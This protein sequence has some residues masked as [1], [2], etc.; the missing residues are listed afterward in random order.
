MAANRLPRDKAVVSGAVTKNAGR[1]KDRKKPKR[2]RPLGVAYKILSAP[3]KKYWNEFKKEMPW[4]NGS[5]RQ[6]LKLACILSCR[7]LKILSCVAL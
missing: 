4:L 6:L 2:T 7:P 1:F 5:H 3:E